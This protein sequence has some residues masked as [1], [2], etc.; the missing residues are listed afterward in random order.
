MIVKWNEN[1]KKLEFVKTYCFN[2]SIKPEDYNEEVDLA[3]NIFLEIW[4]SLKILFIN[5]K[6]YIY[7]IEDIIKSFNISFNK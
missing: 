1:N 4:E 6:I 2:D 5:D 7:T 3:N